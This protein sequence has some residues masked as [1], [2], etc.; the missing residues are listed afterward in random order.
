VPPPTSAY[1]LRCWR[2]RS[3]RRWA[4]EPWAWTR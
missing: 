4:F 3:R 1:G 2:H